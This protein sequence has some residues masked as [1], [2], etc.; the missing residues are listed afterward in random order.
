MDAERERERGLDAG[1]RWAEHA[2][3]YEFAEGIRH[4]TGQKLR[5]IDRALFAY[6][7]FLKRAATLLVS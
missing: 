1:R 3:S 2:S 5:T 7:Q 4:K 6:G